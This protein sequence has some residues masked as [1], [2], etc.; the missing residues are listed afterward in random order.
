MPAKLSDLE[1]QR[2]L[3]GLLGWARRGDVLTKTF[4]FPRFGDGIA[5]VAK[6]AVIADAM[7]HHP[8]IDIRYTKVCFALSTH[9]AGGITQLD[10]D[11]AARI[12]K[13]HAG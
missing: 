1:I 12:E 9:S 7:D 11:L 10:L 13:T 3:G 2:A 8:D 4:S 6:V 5:F